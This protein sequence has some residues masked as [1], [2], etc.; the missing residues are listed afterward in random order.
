MKLKELVMQTTY[1]EIE[2]AIAKA[3][4]SYGSEVTGYRKSNWVKVFDTLYAMEPKQNVD[5]KLR[6]VPGDVSGYYDEETREKNPEYSPYMFSLTA[7]PWSEWLGMEVDGETLSSMSVADILGNCINEMTWWGYDEE[8]IR[9]NLK[10]RFGGKDDEDAEDNDEAKVEVDTKTQSINFIK[11]FVP[12]ILPSIAQKLG[13]SEFEQK[14]IE[15]NCP[16]NGAYCEPIDL[17]PFEMP[18]TGIAFF[19]IYING[20]CMM[21]V[22]TEIEGQF[23]EIVYNWFAPFKELKTMIEADET[24]KTIVDILV[25][26]VEDYFKE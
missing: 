3:F 8:T 23:G 20:N 26:Q 7:T 16:E 13:D 24:Q 9:K 1:E 2:Q 4:V 6:I 17:R 22:T 12:A 18:L 10:E 25:G 19:Y 14:L 11:S 5:M 21:G 15:V